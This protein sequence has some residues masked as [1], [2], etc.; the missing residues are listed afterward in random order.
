MGTKQPLYFSIVGERAEVDGYCVVC[1]WGVGL[2]VWK[3]LGGGNIKQR[4]RQMKA[5]HIL[6]SNHNLVITRRW[7]DQN[8]EGKK[9]R[10]TGQRETR[11]YESRNGGCEIAE[12]DGA[13][14]TQIVLFPK[15]DAYLLHQSLYIQAWALI[16]KGFQKLRYPDSSIPRLPF[17]S[18]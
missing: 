5:L 9:P 15:T 4:T 6:K 11:V 3:G 17:M 16:I 2:A 8:K 14:W 13:S 1:V 12:N 10:P 7:Y 18:F